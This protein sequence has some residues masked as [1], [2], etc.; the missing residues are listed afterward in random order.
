MERQ[1]TGGGAVHLASEYVHPTPRKGRCR[2][3]IY[4]PDAE[5]DH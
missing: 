1:R 4:E 3:R 5:G 2:V